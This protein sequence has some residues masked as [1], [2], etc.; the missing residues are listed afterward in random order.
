[1]AETIDQA[2]AK[3]NWSV[4]HIE[5]C[6]EFL[7]TGD[8][9]KGA[10][11]F[12]ASKELVVQWVR[13]Q[14]L[15]LVQKTK[16]DKVKIECLKSLLGDLNNQEASPNLKIELVLKKEDGDSVGVRILSGNQDQA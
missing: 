8:V 11:L 5:V 4:E 13:T 15:V 14:I 6:N 9:V 7:K 16:S 3:E 12:A 2:L 10:K 1:M